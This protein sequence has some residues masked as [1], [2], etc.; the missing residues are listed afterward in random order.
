MIRVL[1]VLRSQNGMT[2]QYFV[3]STH[4][5]RDRIVGGIRQAYEGSHIAVDVL[6]F[7]PKEEEPV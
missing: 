6:D 2:S 3:F 5:E 4:E 7:D 1:V